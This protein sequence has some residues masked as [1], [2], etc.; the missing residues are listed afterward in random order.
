MANFVANIAK[1][2]IAYYAG[3]PGS[4]DGLEAIP[5]EASGIQT[6]DQLKDHDT[7]A[8]VL[9]ASNNE[10]STMGRQDLTGVSVTV[11][12]TNNRVDISADDIVWTGA[13]GSEV[14]KLLICYVPNTS[15]SGDSDKIPLTFHDFSVEP[16]G[17]DITAT[18]DNGVFARSE[19]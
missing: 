18:I 14:A 6:D 3:L 4:S 16:D 7:V 17:S 5:L 10:Q 19:D 9:A 8:A 15:T 2:K 11:D 12:D 1:G 13:T